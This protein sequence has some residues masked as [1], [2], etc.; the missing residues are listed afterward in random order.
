MGGSLEPHPPKGPNYFNFMGKYMKNEDNVGNE[1]PFDGFEPPFHKS[2]IPE[3]LD[4]PLYS[5]EAIELWL[6]NGMSYTRQTLN[7]LE[8]KYLL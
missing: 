8:V 3:I 1:P 6:L 7:G 2:W 4:P 5:W